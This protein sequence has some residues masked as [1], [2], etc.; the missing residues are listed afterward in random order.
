MNLRYYRN[1]GSIVISFDP[2]EMQDSLLLMELVWED[3]W[4][5]GTKVPD[6]R[7]DFFRSLATSSM[8]PQ[9]KF[10]YQFLEFAIVFLEETCM[11]WAN[12]GVDTLMLEKFLDEITE[13]CPA[14]HTIQ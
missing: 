11:E 3:E 2:A 1:E 4:Y 12:K 8:K 14:G 7:G 6:W 13:F 5:R 9:I 10:D